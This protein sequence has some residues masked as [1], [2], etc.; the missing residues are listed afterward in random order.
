MSRINFLSHAA[1][2]AW[3]SS[4]KPMRRINFLSRAAKAAWALV[5]VV[6]LSSC[7]LSREK[8]SRAS[9]RAA[10]ESFRAV[11][12]DAM[13]ERE[14][15]LKSARDFVSSLSLDERAAQLFMVNLAGDET[16]SAVEK[17]FPGAEEKPLIPGGYIFFSYNIARSPEKTIAFTDSIRAFCEKAGAVQPFLAVD[18]EGGDVQRLKGV[19][20]PL[21]SCAQVARSFSVEEAY[22]LYSAQARQM[23]ALGFTMNLAPVAEEV[24]E[25][26]SRFLGDRSFGGADK[27]VAYGAAAVNAFQNNG[28][29][30]AL[31]HFPGN[32]N[33][34]PHEG[35]S[36]ISFADPLS[37]GRALLPFKRLSALGSEAVVMSHARSREVGDGVPA[38]LS[39]KWIEGI[40]RGELEFRGL[41][42]SDDI[43][44]P[45]LADGGLSPDEAAVRAIAAGV[46][47]VMIS[48]K[49]FL[50]PLE[51]VA[52]K[53]RADKEFARKVDEAAARVVSFKT[54]HGLLRERKESGVWRVSRAAAEDFPDSAKR[55]GSF[56]AARS[57]NE[58][59]LRLGAAS[60]NS[61]AN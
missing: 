45:A 11:C 10:R 54:K 17:F 30:A 58:E 46:D 23:R 44:M 20:A 56:R 14:A 2:A 40:L 43:F 51:A 61:N 26:N 52:K 12:E 6:S 21:P 25:G 53:A 4:A 15:R 5:A 13:K 9:E 19:A 22:R 57:E 28:V 47:V 8:K 31:K 60:V 49:R 34:D 7:G 50:A 36:E 1:K 59:L 29:A 27:A 38:C 42:M 32:A 37:L 24:S 39:E 55:L 41:V 18:Q 48:E 3:A 35:L 33:V 16:F